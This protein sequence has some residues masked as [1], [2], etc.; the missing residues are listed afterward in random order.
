MVFVCGG[1][2]VESAQSQLRSL[3]VSDKMPEFAL[4]DSNGIPF[5]YKH[6]AG[7]VTIIAFLSADQKQSEQ[8]IADIE[9]IL[10]EIGTGKYPLDIVAVM[11]DPNAQKQFA[12]LRK[13]PRINAHVVLDSENKL[14][15]QLGVI[16]TPTFIIAGKDD[17][18]KWI[19]AGYGY[20][21]AS[22]I[23]AHL[24][25]SLGLADANVTDEQIPVQILK[26]DSVGSKVQRHLHLVEMMEKKGQLDLAIA[27]ARKAQQ[28]DP[29]SVEVAICLGKLYCLSGDAKAAVQ[30]ISA[31]KPQTKTQEAEAN[32][33]IGWAYRQIGD[34]DA[35]L[36]ALLDATSLDQKS[37]RGFYELGKI[38]KGKS[39]NEKAMEAYRKALE[40]VFSE[41]AQSVVSH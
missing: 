25:G 31:V 7:R 28:L 2:A 13:E 30:A 36:K 8:S 26:N 35:A 37:S 40:I 24:R 1:I 15:G 4:P 14:W 5:A 16:V 6:G 29:N 34:L 12:F 19:K 17:A 21:F 41:S 11:D 39:D 18:I 33:I 32:V 10:P 3:K 23:K 38:Y 22:L 20:D 27:E 9:K